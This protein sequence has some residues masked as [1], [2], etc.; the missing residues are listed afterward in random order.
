MKTAKRSRAAT[1]LTSSLL[2]VSLL[3]GSLT[4][5]AR[6]G[7]GPYPRPVQARGGATKISSDLQEQVRHEATVRVILQ[8]K[9]PPSGALNAILARQ[10]VRVR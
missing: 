1:R 6:A 7:A 2:L 9:A 5:G 4:A 10:G 8:L 3:M